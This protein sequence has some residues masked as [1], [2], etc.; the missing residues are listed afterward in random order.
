MR[1]ISAEEL[2]EILGQRKDRVYRRLN[3]A[4]LV[5]KPAKNYYNLYTQY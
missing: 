1:R 5:P 2:F 3:L 4:P